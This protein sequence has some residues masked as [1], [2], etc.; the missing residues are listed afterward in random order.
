MH[1]GDFVKCVL[2]VGQNKYVLS[3]AQNKTDV[4]GKPCFFLIFLFVLFILENISCA[5]L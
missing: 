1:C 2:S 4:K 5:S 3:T